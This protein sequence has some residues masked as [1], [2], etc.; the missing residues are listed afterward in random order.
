M[1][2]VHAQISILVAFFLLRPLHAPVHRYPA[3]WFSMYRTIKFLPLQLTSL[4]KFDLSGNPLGPSQSLLRNLALL[5]RMKELRLEKAE[6]GND[7]FPP[8]LFSDAPFPNLRL[9][10]IS[11]T[12]VTFGACK[13]SPEAVETR[14]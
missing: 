5:K 12:Q 10:D 4:T 2:V 8:T 3:L 9:L 13:R 11:E 14:T 1:M 7:S 6:I